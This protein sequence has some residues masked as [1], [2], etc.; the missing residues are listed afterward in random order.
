MRIHPLFHN[1]VQQFHHSFNLFFYPASI[2]SNTNVEF[3]YSLLHA[4]FNA[5]LHPS[6]ESTSARYDWLVLESVSEYN[7]GSF[8]QHDIGVRASSDDEVVQRVREREANEWLGPTPE[9][10]EG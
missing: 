7:R 1:F 9:R 6:Q 10:R 3:Y 8:R 5:P 4:F 2:R